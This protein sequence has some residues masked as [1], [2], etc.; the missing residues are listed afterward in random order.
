M[1]K[2]KKCGG[3]RLG[4][5]RFLRQIAGLLLIVTPLAHAHDFW[6]ATSEWHAEPGTTIIITA[7]V[8]DD[9]FP[10][11][12]YAT[13][14]NRLDSLRLVGPASQDI[15]AQYYKSKNSLATK[16]TLP[17]SPGTYIVAMTV[18]P[19]F[20]SMRI[21]NE[22]LA[23]KS[24]IANRLL[25]AWSSIPRVISGWFPNTVSRTS[26][27]PQTIPQSIPKRSRFMATLVHHGAAAGKE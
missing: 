21:G 12:Q 11:S 6:L 10:I 27:T 26:A 7:N 2:P 20:L 1:P 23:A 22:T 4:C 18:K 13:A 5:H 19:H 17:A 3:S 25:N 16:A 14:A 15:G 8:G 9:S 24:P